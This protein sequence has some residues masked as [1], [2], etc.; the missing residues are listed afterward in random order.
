MFKLVVYLKFWNMYISMDE[1]FIVFN[2]FFVYVFVMIY[3]LN[4]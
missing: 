4:L 1:K 3:L 2:E